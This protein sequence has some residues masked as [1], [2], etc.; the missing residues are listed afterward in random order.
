MDY[1]KDIFPD[2]P[3]LE[4]LDLRSF[5]ESPAYIIDEQAL[6][7]N[8]EILKEIKDK[9]DCK[10]LLALK[11]FSNYKTFPLIKKYLDGCCASSLWEAQLAYEEFGKEVHTYSPSYRSDELNQISSY[12]NHI[13]FNSVQELKRYKASLKGTELGLRI[14]P[15]HSETD[16]ELYNPCSKFSRLGAKL[17]DLEGLDIDAISGFHLH[18]LCQKGADALERTLAVFEEK[19]HKFLPKLKWLN[20][21]GGHH[22]TQVGYD[23]DLLM[24]LINKL[25]TKYDLQVYLE[26]GEAV[27]INTGSLLCTVLDTF[28]SAG[29]HHAIVDISATC[30]MPDVLEM[31]YRPDIRGAGEE[32]Q[33]KFSYRLGGTSCLAGDSIG[34]YSFE[35]ELKRGDRLLF[36]DMSH[37]TMVKTS[38]FNGVR[39][40]SIYLKDKS[41]RDVLLKKFTYEDYR[42]KL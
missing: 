34:I 4:D 21:G 36:D 40:P 27:A 17:A 1:Y 5:P 23:K 25:K 6:E 11:A 38:F 16:V 2:R 9:T 39:H 31:P 19:F 30:H 42:S 8:L 41:R 20:L 28:E 24:R 7:R 10:I 3:Y 35:E 37:Y 12:S 26:P 33:K 15:E 22:I 14:N 29:I 32:G 18:T 13:I